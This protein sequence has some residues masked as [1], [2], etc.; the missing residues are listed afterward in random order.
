MEFYG[1]IVE[2]K[3]LITQLKLMITPA[4]ADNTNIGFNKA[5]G[6]IDSLKIKEK[7]T[8]QTGNDDTKNFEIMVPLKYLSKFW[9]TLEMPVINCEIN[10]GL[11]WSLKSGYSCSSSSH[12]IF[13]N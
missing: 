8:G 9:R 6:I 7:R 2:F 13:N 10:L 11:K 12:S 3:L 5:N 4:L 1:N